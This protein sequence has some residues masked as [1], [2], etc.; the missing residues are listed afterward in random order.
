MTWVSGAALLLVAAVSAAQGSP[1]LS[2]QV[3][4]AAAVAA[5]CALLH[6]GLNRF[7]QMFFFV[8]YVHAE[9]N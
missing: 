4:G 2:A 8:D 5:I 7:R 9:K 1:L 6:K 3:L